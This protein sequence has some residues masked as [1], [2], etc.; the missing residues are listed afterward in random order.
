MDNSINLL[1]KK[2]NYKRT[3]RLFSILRKITLVVGIITFL[4]LSSVF[5]L[6]IQTTNRYQ[7]LAREKERLLKNLL[8]KKE[9]QR[10]L[11]VIYEK[12]AYVSELLKDNPQFVSYI[13]RL[14]QLIPVASESAVLNSFSIDTKKNIVSSISFSD[15]A[16]T[17]EFID[18]VEKKEFLDTFSTLSINSITITGSKQPSGKITVSLTGSVKSL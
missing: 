9:Q 3:A 5:Y 10:K 1:Y 6:T 7:T 11:T 18:A 13:D 15:S 14:Q 12:G 16:S 17:L 2:N 8:P 4:L